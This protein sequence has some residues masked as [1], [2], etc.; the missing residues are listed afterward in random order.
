[1]DCSVVRF[2][3]SWVEQNIYTEANISTLIDE[4]GYSRK[5]LEIWFL[6][7]WNIAP[8][9]YLSR[10]RMSRAAML[11]R[12]TVLPVAE[13]SALF[14]FYSQQ[15]FARAFKKRFGVTPVQ[16][17]KQEK[18]ELQALQKPLFIG[19][20]PLKPEIILLT[21]LR[22]YAQNV[23]HQRNFFSLPDNNE[24]IEKTKELICRHHENNKQDICFGYRVG[25]VL[26]LKSGRE[27]IVQV[28]VLTQYSDEKNGCATVI[29]PAGKYMQFCFTGSWREY[30]TFTRLI[31]FS[32]IVEGG[33]RRDG[34][35]LTFFSFPHGNNEEV[36]CRHLIPVG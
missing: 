19:E 32:I 21:E 33:V 27:E 5:T 26:S 4:I 11:L 9:D 17:R 13:I 23:V 28:E 14:H 30:V 8:G 3:L 31:Y 15:N 1:M 20:Q 18:W 25:P 24:V 22:M 36:T 35:D 6:R 10:R 16:Y 7:H 12:M 29:I 34:F 2:M